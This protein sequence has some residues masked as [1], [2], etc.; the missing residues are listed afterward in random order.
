[1]VIRNA[2]PKAKQCKIGD[3]RSLFL[4]V[5][6]N[7]AKYWR[8]RYR[9][10]GKQKVLALGVWPEVSLAD[11]RAKRDSAR[12]MIVDGIDPMVEKKRWKLRANAR[13]VVS[14]P[15]ACYQKERRRR[16]NLTVRGRRGVPCIVVPRVNGVPRAKIL[17]R[18]SNRLNASS[19]RV[20]LPMSR[21]RLPEK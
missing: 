5:M 16:L 17:P 11:A 10:L 9:F 14:S 19:E 12:R 8:F 13:H 21:L 4:L 1:M 7:G 20:V 18:V 3:G 15:D 6:Q 2:Q